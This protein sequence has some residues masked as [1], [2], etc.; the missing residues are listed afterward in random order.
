[1]FAAA[2][3]AVAVPHLSSASTPAADEAVDRASTAACIKASGLE[4]A[5]VGPITRF[6]DD[7]LV[8]ART[9]TG[10]WPQPH[11]NK[12]QGMVLCL[13]NRRTGRAETQEPT[14]PAPEAPPASAD[15]IRDVW[16]KVAEID[17]RPP[18]GDKPLTLK[19]GADG[20]V[21]GNSGCN[22]YSATYQLN[23]VTLKVLPPMIGTR[24]LCSLPVNGQETRYREILIN[25]TQVNHGPAG[26]MVVTSSN[27]H[28][29][30]FVRQ[31]ED[32]AN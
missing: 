10:A 14:Q 11:M 23:G 3:L 27:G 28:A 8:D 2:A 32:A 22:G 1:V 25:A 12:T 4:D 26:S 16:W 5:T 24:M 17:G 21:G 30:R 13:Y 20:K 6:S 19:F 29:L 9:V 18:V 7:F 31:Q 15:A